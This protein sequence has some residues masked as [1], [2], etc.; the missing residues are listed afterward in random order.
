M[1]QFL[2]NISPIEWGLIAL[3]L[4]VLFG[5]KLVKTLGRTTGETFK[6]IKGIKKSFTEGITGKGEQS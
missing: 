5:G 2:R 4:I 6:E 1:F 3:I